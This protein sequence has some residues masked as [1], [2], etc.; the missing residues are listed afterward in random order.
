M[1]HGGCQGQGIPAIFQPTPTSLPSEI[2]TLL[3]TT[4]QDLHRDIPDLLKKQQQNMVGPIYAMQRFASCTVS[5]FCATTIVLCRTVLG[6][7]ALSPGVGA[8]PPL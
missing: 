4:T 8:R 7:A 5:S 3:S 1:W 6:C 2:F